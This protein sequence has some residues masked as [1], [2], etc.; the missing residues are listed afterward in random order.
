MSEAKIRH[1]LVTAL[2]DSTFDLST[3]Y[4]NVGAFEPD[5]SI[6]YAEFF[7]MSNPPQ[8]VTMGDDGEDLHTGIVQINLNYPLNGGIG[9]AL[10]QVDYLR[11][12]LK[13]SAPLVHESQ[14]VRI[15]TCGI[16]GPPQKVN[17]FYQII[18]SITWRSMSART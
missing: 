13:P 11:T 4:D 16:S 14:V 3:V 8:P 15:R 7:F 10:D 1:A 12:V 5:P 18:V 6:A 2:E 17:G 9:E